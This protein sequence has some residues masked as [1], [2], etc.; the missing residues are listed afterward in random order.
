MSDELLEEW[1]HVPLLEAIPLSVPR[2]RPSGEAPSFL[3]VKIPTFF[4]GDL[5]APL[6]QAG[7]GETK[8]IKRVASCTS[9]A[10]CG[11]NWSPLTISEPLLDT[12]SEEVFGGAHL[13]LWG[14]PLSDLQ[15]SRF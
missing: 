6:P 8:L 9:D 12:G 7:S 4:M 10:S 1:G 14:D 13:V 2:G 3:A 11:S 5:T 15:I